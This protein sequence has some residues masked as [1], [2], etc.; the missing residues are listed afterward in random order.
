[1][2]KTYSKFYELPIT[3]IQPHGWL[4]AYLETQRDGL[5]GH[6]EAAG[7]PFDQGGWA[8]H[9]ISHQSGSTWW[10]YEQTG[11]WLDGMARCGILLNDP[12]L[13]E[14]ARQTIEYTLQHA[15]T[16]GYLGPAF[17]K[18][19]LPGKRWGTNNR[20]PHTIFFRALIAYD[21][22]VGGD[23]L[24]QAV[25]RH[26]LSETSP[27]SEARDVTNVETMLWAYVR[28]S[29]DRLLELAKSAFIEYNHGKPLPDT[30]LAELLS[31]KRAT[32]HG[33]TF[34]EIGKLGAVLY[35]Y[36]GN[37]MYLDSTVNAYR[38]LDL[39]Q[40]LVDGVNSSSEALRGKDPLDS[41]E[42]C[43][44]AD[45]TWGVGYLL[46]TLG[47]GEYADKIERACFNAA[48]GAVRSDFKGLQYFSCPNQVV[49]TRASNHNKYFHGSSWMSYR[50]NP[51]TECC[52]GEVNRIMPNYVSRMWLSDGQ[53]GL[54]AALYGPS[55]VTARLGE[56]AQEVTIQEDTTYPFS[57]RIDFQFKLSEPVEFPLTLRIPG[58]CKAAELLLNGQPVKM[59][60][61]PGRFVTLER[62]FRDGDRISL[63]LP[64]SLRMQH[65]PRLGVSLERGPLVFS[66][67]IEE[68]WRIDPDDPRSTPDFPAWD[69]YPASTWN[70]ALA[71]DPENLEKEVR[72]IQG[73]YSDHP[74]SIAAAPLTLRVPARRL[75]GWSVQKKTGILTSFGRVT[76]RMKGSFVFTPQLPNPDGI[77]QRLGKQVEMVTL[78]PYGCSKLRITIFPFTYTPRS[79]GED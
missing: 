42:T 49:A 62:R 26:Y 68:D 78:V 17:M 1:M 76:K 15:D 55:Q 56:V 67:R 6:L 69:L 22:F 61:S 44:I 30:S 34:N 11:Y 31:D 24:A 12:F 20:W 36:T 59:T 43:D 28:T 27:H 58:W 3:S 60:L 39:D 64:M 63:L 53:G 5:T 37:Q 77:A 32:V 75:I 66:L 41:H 46:L 52:P 13:I 79:S 47:A 51:G 45:Y 33:V 29:D 10:P 71:L 19:P 9:A 65:W 2:V 4:R 57:E 48:P 40:M 70:Y 25:R 38:K 54:V 21:Q 16:D 74:W 18:Q 50:P 7:F 8:N 35:R 72:V 23:R 14:K 73:K